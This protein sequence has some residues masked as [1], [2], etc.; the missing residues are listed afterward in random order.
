MSTCHNHPG[1]AAAGTCR[2]C[3]CEFCDE[4]LVYAF[5]KGRQPYC[6]DCAVA[7]TAGG[8]A[9]RG[10]AARGVESSDA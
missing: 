4:C 9:G 5:G 2:E 8:G 10:F 3:L 7:V 6:V 1:Q